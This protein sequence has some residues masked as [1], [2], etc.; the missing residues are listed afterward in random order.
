[1]SKRHW[2]QRPRSHW[3]WWRN[4]PA[5]ADRRELYRGFEGQTVFIDTN[6]C[7]LASRG[8]RR[9]DPLRRPGLG[10]G[11]VPGRARRV[12]TRRRAT[13][14]RTGAPA[15]ERRRG[16]GSAT[17]PSQPHLRAGRLALRGSS[18][19]RAPQPSRPSSPVPLPRRQQRSFPYVVHGCEMKLKR[20]SSSQSAGKTPISTVTTAEMTIDVK[21]Y[22]RRPA[23]ITSTLPWVM[24]ITTRTRM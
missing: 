14:D 15:D 5:R 21:R 10:R 24:N 1:M 6:R 23:P 16:M 3:A 7:A 17:A 12:H 13:V 2:L 22:G 18:V 9:R 4:A 19:Q 8:V 20:A 11:I